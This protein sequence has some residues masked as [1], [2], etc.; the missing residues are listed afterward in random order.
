MPGIGSYNFIKLSGGINPG[1]G[2]QVEE[3]TRAGVDGVAF[4]KIGK[5][6][7]AFEMRSVVDVADAAAA[8]TLVGNY[9]ALQ[10]SIVNIVD[11]TGRTWN[12]YIVLRV[13]PIQ[14]RPVTSATGG[15]VNDPEYLVSASWIMQATEAT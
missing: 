11:D 3:I 8:Q 1:T 9:K 2:E 15:L 7:F 12:N 13:R 14:A 6:G 5:R 4:R 10:G